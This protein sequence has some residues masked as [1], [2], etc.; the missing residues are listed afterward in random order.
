LS[1]AST[2]RHF[3]IAT[4]EDV[5]ALSQFLTEMLT[6]GRRP[7]ATIEYARKT[8]TVRQNASLHKFLELLAESLNDAG[9]DMR[10]VLKPEVDIPWTKD[11]AKEFLWR[12]LQKALLGEASTAKASTVDYT[13][14][15]DVLAR[16]M[17]EKHGLRVPDWPSEESLMRAGQ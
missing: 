14:V 3:Q 13:P 7:L 1:G 4:A 5:E 15:Y 2:V 11:S 16:H 12:P 6:A 10:I 8:R 9:L 17:A